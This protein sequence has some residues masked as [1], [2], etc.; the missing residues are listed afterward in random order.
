MDKVGYPASKP[1]RVTSSSV[2]GRHVWIAG[3]DNV[4]SAATQGSVWKM[5][6][7]SI[8]T[9]AL[10]IMAENRHFDYSIL[11]PAERLELAQDLWDSVDQASDT[12]VLPLT[13]EQ[14]AELDRRL[15]ELSENPDAGSPWPEVKSRI[16]DKFRKGD[17]HKRGA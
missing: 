17:R 16:L 4:R 1:V 3:E 2:A 11:T 14:R 8:R 7:Q 15:E 13:D 10:W 12:S 5:P 6:C 9:S